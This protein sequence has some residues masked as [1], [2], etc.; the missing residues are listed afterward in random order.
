MTV[1][2]SLR[3]RLLV[4]S[5]TL[6][7]VALVTFGTWVTYSTWRTRLAEVDRAL[8]VRLV[9]L[10]AAVQPASDGA[11]D[12]VIPADALPDAERDFYLIW[13]AHDRLIVASDPDRARERPEAGRAR[14]GDAREHVARLPSGV[15]ILV[16]RR[17]DTIL[18]EIARLLL[19]MAGVGLTA[20]ALVIGGNWWMIGRA[21]A[22]VARI[23]GTARAMID[24]DL[25]ARIPL[26]QVE[27][28]LEQLAD[29]LNEAFDRLYASVERQR[30]FTADASH[31]L[32]TPLTI[33]QTETHWALARPRT[34][35]ELK[36]SLAVCQRTAARM[37][38][39]VQTLLDLARAESADTADGP[40]RHPCAISD[41]VTA[42]VH[43][44]APLA[45]AR[46][47][48][49]HTG[50]LP[51]VVVADAVSLR[52][53]VTNLITNAIQYNVEGGT[54]HVTSGVTGHTLTVAV[55]D[56]GVGLE[57]HHAARVFDRFYRVDTSRTGGTGGAGIGLATVA[58]FARSHGGTVGIKSA[59]GQGSTFMVHLPSL[60][61]L[62]PAHTA[63]RP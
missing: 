21:L 38:T 47:I 12:L 61:A 41:V 28:E 60:D 63:D 5:S 43:E 1:F 40:D 59:P 58:A 39:L 49:V 13:D 8:D 7:V 27:S 19:V 55:R 10:T 53:A 62:P 29:V 34:V 17:I 33:L 26:S 57:P 9:T 44:V 6:L 51:G 23:G 4:W 45:S 32:R 50:P 24:G 2:H 14:V 11:F 20:L 48:Q 31:D 15:T 54:V 16:G 30:R 36:A 56:S 18:A 3:T 46:G 22:P 52:N 35:E 42:V 37:Q 25:S